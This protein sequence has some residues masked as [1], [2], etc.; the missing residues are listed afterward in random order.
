MRDLMAG[1]QQLMCLHKLMLLRAHARMQALVRD[2][3]DRFTSCKSTIDDIYAKL[4]KVCAGFEGGV[5]GMDACSACIYI[6][7]C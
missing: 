2:N 4:K 5:G 1:T 6:H 7:A 3:F